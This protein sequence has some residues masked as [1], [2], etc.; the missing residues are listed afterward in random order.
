M[1][2]EWYQIA[3]V[4]GIPSIVSGLVALCIN[5]GMK[6]R[7]AKQ[8]EIRLQTE[9]ME[10]QNKALMAGVQA[11]LRDRLLNGYRHYSAKGWADY[12]DRQNME[13]MWEQYH[14]LGANGVMDGYRKKFLELPEHDPRS[15][16]LY[17][18][19]N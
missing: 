7:D 11:I 6:K 16:A 10:K 9:I 15:A 18:A 4:I 14:A 1:D 5:R 12:D 19:A 3:M 8:E 13:N 17:R 2:M